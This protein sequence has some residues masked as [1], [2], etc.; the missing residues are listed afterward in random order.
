MTTCPKCPSETLVATRQLGDIL[1]DVCPNCSG[2][3]FDR[4]ELEALLEQSHGG[5]AADLALINAGPGALAC[6]RC[7]SL[8]PRGGLVNPLLLVDRCGSCGGTWLDSRELDLVKKLLGL[9]GGSSEAAVSRPAAPRPVSAAPEA[10]VSGLR[11]FG[12]LA[13]AAG[14]IGLF[15]EI[16]LYFVPMYVAPSAA[17]SSV[18]LLLCALGYFIIYRERARGR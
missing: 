11:K 16:Y 13:Y 18:F 6:P 7:K 10:R 5:A 4:G 14:S 8:M 12:A 17:L 1:L 15:V 9:S 2:I 3:W